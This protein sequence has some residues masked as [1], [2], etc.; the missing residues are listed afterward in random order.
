M[1]ANSRTVASVQQAPHP[2]LAASV[3]RHLE[4]DWR[5]PPAAHSVQAFDALRACIEAAP[6]PL[7]LDAGCGTG[8]STL[9]LA[10]L[11]ADC[12]V[13]GVDKSAARLA[14]GARALA[15]AGAPRNALL[16]RAELADFWR[17][18]HAAGWRLRRQYLLYPNPWP[19][20]AQL[21]RRWHAHPA[22]AALLALGGMLELRC[23]WR[24]Y[25][26]EF[27]RALDVA[28]IAANVE[29]F[30]PAGPLTPFERKYAASGHA[31]WRVGARL[32]TNTVAEG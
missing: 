15:T 24:V 21:A 25:A 19:K 6:R 9:R 23:N 7:V 27:A 14:A 28:G 2:R 1:Y 16:V 3:R 11:H 12:W 18:A 26:D 13:I 30:V 17:L 22:F 5:R 31:L 10:E 20:P 4:T 29:A 8:A 32:D